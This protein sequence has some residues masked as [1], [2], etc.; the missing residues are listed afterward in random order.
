MYL[1]SYQR[2]FEVLN[3]YYLGISDNDLLFSMQFNTN[4]KCVG[5]QTTKFPISDKY[6]LPLLFIQS[7]VKLLITISPFD[8]KF[9]QH[10][11]KDVYQ[12]LDEANVEEANLKIGWIFR[13]ILPLPVTHFSPS[14]NMH[15]TL[16]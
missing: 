1:K 8:G 15:K 12:I 14:K 4:N 16:I 9:S 5:T 2:I 7:L 6:L 10:L 3:E 11:M 13:I